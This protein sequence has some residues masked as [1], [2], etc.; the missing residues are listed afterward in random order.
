M[1]KLTVIVAVYNAEKTLARCV[2]SIL[3]QSYENLEVI[4]VND[5][6][7]DRSLDICKD[8]Q[9]KDKRV[10]VIDKENGGISSARNAGLDVAKGDYISFVDSDDY[11][12]P[13]AY[14]TMMTKAVETDVDI[15]VC[16][17]NWM[18]SDGV[19]YPLNEE[20]RAF[21]SAVVSGKE[22]LVKHLYASPYHNGVVIA[23]WNKIIKAERFDGL[24]LK[25]RFAE[26]EYL[27]NHLITFDTKVAVI[28]EPFYVYTQNPSSVTNLAFSV[29]RLNLLGVLLQRTELF[30]SEE[31]LSFHVSK[32]FCD[33]TMEYYT[34]P[35][36]RGKEDLMAL[37]IK[38]FK[39]IYK[40]IKPQLDKSFKRR[41]QVFA[42]SP[43]LYRFI[44]R[45]RKK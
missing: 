12:L 15:T 31:K 19:I 11:L 4:L 13:E 16:L 42:V 41:A 1:K 34:E 9:S 45:I 38:E 39:R 2:D 37:Y 30:A 26:D 18:N 25:G 10:K 8:Y 24:R 44:V 43:R 5:G 22:L 36:M 40:T 3:S 14:S 27:V 29:E 20:E 28:S 21:E 32:L 35:A 7:K 17:W 6:S 33:I 23:P